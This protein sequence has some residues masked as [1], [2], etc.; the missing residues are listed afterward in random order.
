MLV[1]ICG[2]IGSGK[3]AISDILIEDHGFKPL[4]FASRLKDG[5]AA[6]FGW[7]RELLE[8]KTKESREWREQPD[9][10]WSKEFGH[11]VTPRYTLQRV[12]TECMRVGFHDNIWIKLVENVIE[13]DP[14]GNFVISDARF[15]NEFDSIRSYGGEIWEV[16]RGEQPKWLIDFRADDR[17]V[18]TDIHISEWAWVQSNPDSVIF[19]DATLE[20]LKIKVDTFI[21][22]A[23]YKTNK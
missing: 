14:N 7:N 16:R 13:N 18:P 19:N 10:F 15:P 5:V 1:G 9:P 12:G 8:G 22:I 6:I 21:N 11:A 2:L 23:Y 4:S 20:D 3:G 17:N